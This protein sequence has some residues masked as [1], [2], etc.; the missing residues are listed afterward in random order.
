MSTSPYLPIIKFKD[1]IF[2]SG[3]GFPTPTITTSISKERTSSY[4]YLGSKQNIKLNGFIVDNS[5]TGLL[6][7]ARLLNSG[8]LHPDPARFELIINNK[9]VISGTGFVTSLSFDTTKNNGIQVLTYDIDIDFDST[10][11]GEC[12]I[13]DEEKKYHVSNVADNI[14]ID[15]SENFYSNDAT[16]YPL[17]EITR[18]ISA[19]GKL[20]SSS[21]SLVEAIDWINDRRRTFPFTGIIPTGEFPLFNHIR[22]IELNELEGNINITDK[23]ISKPIE[24]NRPWIDLYTVDTNISEDL[25][26]EVNIKGTILGLIPVTGLSG[27]EG[28]FTLDVVK[29]GHKMFLPFSNLA[30]TGTKYDYAL[31][32]Y[33][34]ITGNN[35]IAQRAIVHYS[36]ISELSR[37]G[38]G[39][40]HPS[41]LSQLPLNTGSPTN[42]VETFNPFKGEITYNITYNNRPSARISGALSELITITDNAQLP[43]IN[44]I[45]VLGRRLGPVVYFFTESSGLGNRSVTYEGVFAAPTGVKQ[46]YINIEI[47]KSIDN[48]VDS[49][50]PKSPKSGYIVGND[51]KINVNEHRITRTKT[52][53]YT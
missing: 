51:Q 46:S 18:T 11:S 40:D 23:F 38:I 27:I 3:G 42:F 5:S 17:Y 7:K 14:T 6:N 1:F 47:L 16:F 8:I 37:K 4:Q 39:Y 52:W 24:P 35:L 21:G 53:S 36:L 12:I 22:N 43:R 13:N 28:P 48:L 49:Y 2:E 10:V 32:G 34:Y 41:D 26:N 25:T 9:P 31:S 33:S 19:Q 20:S 29:S 44:S 50:A 15:I 45:P 30:N